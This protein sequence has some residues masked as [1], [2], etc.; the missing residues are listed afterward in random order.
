M[1]IVRK[2]THGINLDF[3][4]ANETIEVHVTTSFGPELSLENGTVLVF[5][6]ASLYYTLLT[7]GC[8]TEKGI[9]LDTLKIMSTNIVDDDV[10]G[11]LY[12]EINIIH[13]TIYTINDSI[14]YRFDR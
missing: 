6:D 3:K 9:D 12:E 10:S 4:S 11:V 5:T 2:R 14:V 7:N 13:V 8:I 1:K